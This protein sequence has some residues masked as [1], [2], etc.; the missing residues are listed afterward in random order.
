VLCEPQLGK[1]GLYPNLSTKES[2]KQVRDMMNL[3]AYADGKY[4]LID[5]AN[6]V[7]VSAIKLIPI[8]EKLIDADLL[9]V[10][11]TKSEE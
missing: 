9:E 8:V 4:D 7:G 6:I 2:G 1:R 11:N 5:I 3:I 10:V